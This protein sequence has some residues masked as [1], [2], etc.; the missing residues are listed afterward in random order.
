MFID[1]TSTAPVLDWRRCPK[2][3]VVHVASIDPFT[4]NVAR[5]PFRAENSRLQCTIEADGVDTITHANIKIREFLIQPKM[6]PDQEALFE[7]ACFSALTGLP[8]SMSSM[9][10]VLNYDGTEW[11]L[12]VDMS[13]QEF[14]GRIWIPLPLYDPLCIDPTPL[15][16]ELIVSPEPETVRRSAWVRLLED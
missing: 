11:D 7:F 4:G 1:L 10:L 9:S 3:L 2:Q 15:Q 5:Q 6:F 14:P 16:E 8:Q 13:H 12:G